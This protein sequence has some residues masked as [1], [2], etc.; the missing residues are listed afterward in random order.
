MS[1]LAYLS[2]DVAKVVPAIPDADGGGRVAQLGREDVTV[3]NR[4]SP[5]GHVLLPTYKLTVAN[6][7]LGL[8]LEG[9]VLARSKILDC[10][11]TLRGIEL[12]T[13]FR[14]KGLTLLG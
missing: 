11:L 10:S 5:D 2:V 7:G 3:W 4:R 6:P 12:T 8:N 1:G 9:V 14:D 13:I